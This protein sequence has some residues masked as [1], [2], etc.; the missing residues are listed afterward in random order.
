MKDIPLLIIQFVIL[1][2]RLLQPGGMKAIAAENLLLKKQLF[3]IKHARGRVP[4]LT[5]LDRLIFGWLAMMLSPRRLARSAIII[6]PS[7]LLSFHMAL[8][9]KK[10]LR[11]FSSHGNRKPGPNGPNNELIKAIVIIKRRNP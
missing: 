9:R 2:V 6:K 1:L 7:T 11:L 4:N 5:T 3:V 8:V 10:Y